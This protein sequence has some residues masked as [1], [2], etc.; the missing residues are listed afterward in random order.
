MERSEFK[1]KSVIDGDTEITGD[2]GERELK[3]QN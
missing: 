2:N 1:A 3:V